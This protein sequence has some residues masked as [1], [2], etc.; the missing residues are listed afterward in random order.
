MGLKSRYA[1]REKAQLCANAF[2]RDPNLR[3]LVQ[4]RLSRASGIRA[5]PEGGHQD[6]RH[7]GEECRVVDRSIEHRGRGEPIEAQAGD[8]RV[9]LPMTARRVV[10]QPRPARA[11]AIAAQQ[12]G[13]DAALIE[14]DVLAH[15]AQGLPRLPQSAGR[16]DIRAP[17]FIG[18]YRFF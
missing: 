18:V 13:S 12:I 16:G 11:P 6:L 15:L 4:A 5:R 1:G 10:M 14:K 8:D 17:L 3:L 7:V 2:D 9:R